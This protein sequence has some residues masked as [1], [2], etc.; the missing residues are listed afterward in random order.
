MRP[1]PSNPADPRAVAVY[2]ERGV[3]LGYLTAERCGRIGRLLAEGREIRTV[4]Q[5]VTTWGAVIRVA[6]DG[7]IPSLPL[8]H[9]P[10]A[11]ADDDDF[12]PDLIYPDK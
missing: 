12:W 3:Q 1:E 11:M 4:F 10:G 6:F 7:E 8:E 9:G 5:R 2:S